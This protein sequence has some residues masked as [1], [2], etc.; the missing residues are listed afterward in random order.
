MNAIVTDGFDLKLFLVQSYNLQLSDQELISI[1]THL[2]VFVFLLLLV[3]VTS[4][5]KA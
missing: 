2:V 4:S 3:R 1:A 5:K